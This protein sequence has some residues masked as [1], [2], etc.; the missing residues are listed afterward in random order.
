MKN[1]L[2]NVT[3]DILSKFGDD[4]SD[5]AVVFPNRRAKLYMNR[6]ITEIA[7]KP[8]FSPCYMS[9]SELFSSKTSRVAA[10]RI[11]AV[12]TLYK[13][14]KRVIPSDETIDHFWGWGEVMLDDFDDM[15]KHLANVPIVLSNVGGLHAFD[16]ADY[17]SREQKELLKN[18]FEDFTDDHDTRLK[19]RFKLLW[20]NLYTIYSE[21]NREMGEKNLAYEGAMFREVA[22]KAGEIEWEHMM[23]VFVGF[24]MLWE[25]EQKLF[26]ILKD[27]GKALFYWDF[28]DY[29]IK[30]HPRHEAGEYI[31]KWLE[32]FPNELDN[33]DAGLYDNFS[34]EKNV[35]FIS[36]P[37]ENIQAR[38]A[39]KWLQGR[40]EE[41]EQTAIVLADERLAGNVIRYLPGEASGK[42]N[43]TMG[44]PLEETPVCPLVE[45]FLRLHVFASDFR[46]RSYKAKQAKLLLSHPYAVLLSENVPELA[47]TLGKDRSFTIGENMLCPDGDEGLSLLFKAVDTSSPEN[48]ATANAELL[49]RL[50]KI[51]TLIGQ[52]SER[53]KRLRQAG[54]GPDS[55]TESLTYQEN[56]LQESVFRM[57]C[58]VNR[59]GAIIEKEKMEITPATLLKFIKQCVASATMPLNGEPVANIQIAGVMETRNLDFDHLLILSCNEG[60]MPRGVNKP[61]IMPHSVRLAHGLSSSESV[62]ARNSMYFYHMMQ[63]CGDITVVYN[64]S[65]ED[66]KTGQMSRFMLQLMAETDSGT[67]HLTHK[68]L[69]AAQNACRTTETETEKD[70][71]VMERLGEITRLT[72]SAINRYMRCPKQF[73]Y[74]RIMGIQEAEDDEVTGGR[75]FGTVFHKAVE[76]LYRDMAEEGAITGGKID[77]YLNDKDNKKILKY[78][79]EAVK[80]EYF[81]GGTPRYD[82]LQLINRGVICRYI[83]NLLE[84]DRE[85]APLYIEGL[86]TEIYEDVTVTAGGEKRTITVGGIIDR[87]DRIATPEGGEALRVIDYKTGGKMQEVLQRVEDVFDG[88]NIDGKHS[89]YYL[90]AMLY[91]VLVRR[92]EEPFLKNGKRYPA[93]NTRGL[94]VRPAL[95]FIQKRDSIKDPVLKF[96]DRKNTAPVNDILDYET[97][98]RLLLKEKIAEIFDPGTPFAPTDVAR[99]CET[100]AYR[101][102]CR[103]HRAT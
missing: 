2:R 85:L 34:G 91:S 77:E 50:G 96:G 62:V 83:R 12:S 3:E 21:F 32:K 74:N 61:S 66:G 5:V 67:F 99:R 54:A 97:D 38:Y 63:R 46:T 71:W 16:S 37:T 36:A 44:L 101:A 17:I 30:T 87:L 53:E 59:V 19:E 102:I 13:V 49:D 73:Y 80:E 48:H 14:Y 90:Q 58:I 6:Y 25:T 76:T 11:E 28:D 88:K 20:N 57:Y 84:A 55:D 33:D 95:L 7:D 72:P 70:E 40:T 18:F 79:D 94:P 47:D 81:H 93:L 35:T 29:Y 86:E 41:T 1:F 98:F 24:N 15:D 64:S 43:I 9:I 60:N 65:T 103:G 39:G 52:Q 56:L 26:T 82:G 100:C 78:I 89:D 69:G 51:L 92:S 27:R 45:N 23:Y 68:T 31:R 42:T 75:M 4:L 8:L 10:D 22:E